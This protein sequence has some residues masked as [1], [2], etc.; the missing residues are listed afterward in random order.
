MSASFSEFFKGVWGFEPFP[1]Q[2]LLAR[3]VQQ[4]GWPEVL[5]LPTGSGKTAALDIALYHLAIDGGRT[6]PRRIRAARSSR[7]A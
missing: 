2:D 4:S 5:D 3:R 7:A 1:W 6:A